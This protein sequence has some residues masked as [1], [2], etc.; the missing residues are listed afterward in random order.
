MKIIFFPFQI[1]LLLLHSIVITEIKS[2]LSFFFGISIS[3]DRC[4][5]FQFQS[6]ANRTKLLLLLL[7]AS[8][9]IQYIQIY[10]L[11]CTLFILN[12]NNIMFTRRKIPSIHPLQCNRCNRLLTTVRL[13]I[14]FELIAYFWVPVA[15]A[16][17]SSCTVW[18]IYN[19]YFG[20]KYFYNE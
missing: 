10:M 18:N 8:E 12:G 6:S 9:C 1:L 17:Q 14:R 7:F 19:T 4:S 20:V 13:N 15:V 11:H 2:I 5:W 3:E 16:V